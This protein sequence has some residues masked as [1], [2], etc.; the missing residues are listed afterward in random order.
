MKKYIAL[1]VAL[2]V[3]IALLALVSKSGEPDVT[4]TFAAETTEEETT[5][6]AA[7]Q[8]EIILGYYEDKSL[9]PYLTDSPA[10]RNLSTLLYDGLY[11]LD[12]NY[13]PQPVIA[14]SSERDTGRL[15]V[16]L[17][18]DMCFSSGSPLTASDVVYSFNVA[19]QS[20]YYTHRL[21]AFTAAAAG[22][23]SV[24]FSLAEE[25]AYAESCLTFPVIQ[26]G[27]AVNDI[28]VGSGRYVLQSDA[29]GKFLTVNEN[30]SR[31]E[32]MFTPK[33]S[34][35]SITSEQNELY[36]LQAGDLSYFFDDLSDGEYT[37]ISANMLR[38]PLNNLVF[39]GMNKSSEA[40]SDPAVKK[41]ISLAIDK[42]SISEASYSGMCRTADTPFNPDWYVVEPFAS[43]SETF[44]NLKATR[45]LEEA[46]YIYAYSNNK[47]RSKN[48]EF[49]ELTM[50]VNEE[51]TGRVSCA[52]LIHDSLENIGIDVRLFI[53]PFEEYTEELYEGDFDI[54]LGE[55]KLPAS[56]DLSCFFTEGGSAGYGIDSNSTVASSYFDLSRGKTNIS[57]FIT[58]FNNALPFIPI[59]Y[60]DGVAYY[61]REIS[62]EGSVTEY[63]PFLN[64]YSWELVAKN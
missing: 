51:S 53:L 25:N 55:V 39:L 8:N 29:K 2:C 38:V 22:T 18:P 41:A 40:L 15:T 45:T 37:K 10:N 26:A 13:C 3:V 12:E 64:A 54:Y 34:L 31:N 30:S 27:T 44:S 46:G 32:E 63:E 62:F 7:P 20:S 50:L 61:S 36:L 11:V 49:L 24:V 9:N 57:T 14:Q 19:K 23:D 42:A 48:F 28:P 16:Y 59:C 56:M 33:I 47:F 35:V 4:E 6:E 21:D 60:R 43:H 17:N 1:I 5:A 58:V 52:Q